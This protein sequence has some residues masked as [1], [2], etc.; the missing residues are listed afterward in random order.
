[1]FIYD[2]TTGGK[3]GYT[4]KAKRTLVT[5]ASKN[6]LNL[7]AVTLNDGND[8]KDHVNLFEY[9]FS[10][11]I[12]EQVLTKGALNIYDEVYYGN[13]FLSIDNDFSYPITKDENILLKFELNKEPDEGVVGLVKVLVNNE[14]IYQDNIDAV[15]IETHTKGLMSWFR[16][17]W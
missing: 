11:Y 1:M 4:K 3:T 16:N 6:N 5:T 10:N 17:I 14:E 13:Y 7:V 15:K 8:F 2:Y 12:N 9:G